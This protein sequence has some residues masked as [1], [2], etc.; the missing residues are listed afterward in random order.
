MQRGVDRDT[1]RLAEKASKRQ[2]EAEQHKRAQDHELNKVR[3]EA[4]QK[5]QPSAGYIRKGER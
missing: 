2:K 5:L 1:A 3:E 4:W